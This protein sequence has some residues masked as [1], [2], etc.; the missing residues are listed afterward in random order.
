M[1]GWAHRLPEGL[2][3]MPFWGA[4]IDWLP[5]CRLEQGS[6]FV[7]SLHALLL[8]AAAKEN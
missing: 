8:K 6:G 2:W 3:R 1:L 5:I 4:A 7:C